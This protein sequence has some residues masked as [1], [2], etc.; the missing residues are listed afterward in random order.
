M[1]DRHR[2]GDA[3]VREGGL[4][5]VVAEERV[6]RAGVG[7]CDSR[8][9]RHDECDRDE[10]GSAHPGSAPFRTY[11]T[12]LEIGSS[13]MSVAPAAFSCGISVLTRRFSTTV[14]IA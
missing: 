2:V 8:D 10:R 6:E 9:E 14:S 5:P 7:S 3:A 13:R 12:I 11:G 4:D 1:I